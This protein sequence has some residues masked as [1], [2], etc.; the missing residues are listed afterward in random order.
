MI[1]K[2]L[3]VVSL[4]LISW[5]ILIKYNPF[6]ISQHQWQDNIITAEKFMFDNDSINNV[7]V[8]SSLARRLQMDSIPHFY[9]LSFGGQS[10]FDGLNIIETK[11]ILPKRIFIEINVV[12][13]AE[14][15]TFNEIV[16]SPVLNTLKSN[17]NIFRADKQPLA[18]FGYKAITP[19]VDLFFGKILF[20]IRDKIQ[21]EFGVIKKNTI[22]NS[23]SILFNKMLSMQKKNYS[24]HIDNLLIE[25]QFSLLF[26]HVKLLESKGVTVVFFEMPVNHQ[27]QELYAIKFI[28]NKIIKEYPNNIFIQLPNSKFIFKTTDGIHLTKEESKIY[29]SYFRKSVE[30]YMQIQ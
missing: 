12:M 23:D 11:N 3:I 20:R 14:N 2:S 4:L 27:L 17:V 16:T 29:S 15:T 5:S 10:I 21:V 28:R 25:K 26:K 9:N 30:S 8:G 19:L 22:S 1:K 6:S 24:T 7:I 13:Q 18:Y